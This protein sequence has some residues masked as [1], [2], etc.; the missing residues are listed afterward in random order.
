MRVEVSHKES[1]RKQI[2]TLSEDGEES[3]ELGGLIVWLVTGR[4]GLWGLRKISFVGHDV[5]S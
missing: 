1:M 4:D 2:Y 3:L 5:F